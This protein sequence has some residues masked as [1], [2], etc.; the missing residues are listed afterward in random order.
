M[1]PTFCDLGFSQP[2]NGGLPRARFHDQSDKKS[3][4]GRLSRQPEDT[5]QAGP[6]TQA[7]TVLPAA[8]ARSRKLPESVFQR[9]LNEEIRNIR[10]RLKTGGRGIGVSP[11]ILE[12]S[13]DG[14][15]WAGVKGL[16]CHE[17]R[18]WNMRERSIM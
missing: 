6:A 4:F 9:K 14:K 16:A 8:A 1:I 18:E 5:A 3:H 13:L 15:A 12:Y 11:R 2:S 17:N 10:K 7:G